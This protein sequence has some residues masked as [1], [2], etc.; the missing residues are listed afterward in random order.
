MIRRPRLHALPLAVSWLAAMA[1][2]MAQ[3]ADPKPA[4]AEALFRE[5]RERL[6]AG[7][8]AEACPKLAESQRLDPHLGTLLNLAVCHARQGRTATAWGEFAA[9]AAEAQH[10]GRKENEALARTQTKALAGQ[11][12]RIVITPP[13]GPEPAGLVVKLDGAVLG[14]G[15]LGSALPVDPGAHVVDASA[16]GRG[17]VHL[18]VTAGVGPATATIALPELVTVAITADAVPAPEA[19]ASSSAARSYTGPLV[20]GSV[21]L[22]AAGLGTAFGLEAFAKNRDGGAG[23]NA[24]DQ[25]P[26][27]SLDTTSQGRSFATGSDIAFGVAAAAAVSAIVWLVVDRPRHAAASAYLLPVAGGLGASF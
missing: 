2:G 16:P 21:A 3:A 20:L 24:R 9:A 18:A 25:C 12:S 6:E 10:A 5:G 26:Q 7:A 15:A 23:C 11:L 19:P 1:P 17:T 14:S 22:V 27:S 8:Y 13:R 4:L